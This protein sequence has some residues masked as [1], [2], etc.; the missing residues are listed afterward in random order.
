MLRN[1]LEVR[2]YFTLVISTHRTGENQSIQNNQKGQKLMKTPKN[3]KVLLL[4][5]PEKDAHSHLVSSNG[6]L[7]P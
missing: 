5:G 7:D 4:K 6:F 1:D 3:G 2:D